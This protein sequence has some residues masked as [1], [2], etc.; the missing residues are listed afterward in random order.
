MAVPLPLPDPV[1]CHALAGAAA[2]VFVVGAAQKVRDWPSFRSALG[3]YRLLPD[4]LVTPVALALP[5]LE[6]VAGLT[7]LAPSFRNA[8][9]LLA[10]AL[11]AIVT[12]AVAI[13]LARGRTDIDCGCGGAEGRQR[14]SRGL[15]VRNAVLLLAVAVSVQQVGARA[16][17]TLDYATV[18]FASLA[19]YGL[20]ACASQ[21]L[22]NRPRLLEFGNRG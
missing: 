7:L 6:L 22:A 2:L 15:V 5:A 8:G 18:A 4:A 20:Y 1:V 3:A 19:L 10:A 16:L 12:G 14:L 21:L 13:N 9:A 17:G 11:L